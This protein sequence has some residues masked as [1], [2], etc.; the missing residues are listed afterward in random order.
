M[1]NQITDTDNLIDTFK[2]GDALITFIIPTMNRITLF[3]TVHSLLNQT[4]DNWKAILIF[5]GCSPTDKHPLLAL[6]DKRFL[7]ITITKLGKENHAGYIRNIGLE[8]ADTPWVGFVDDDDA[9]TSRYIERLEEEIAI[10]PSADAI[11]FKMADRG[12]IIPPLNYNQI[13]IGEVGISFAYRHSLVKEGFLFEPSSIED[14]TLLKKMQ[15]AKKR[16]VF[17]PH[18]TYLVRFCNYME[19][20]SIRVVFN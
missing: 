17:S 2:G 13:V 11:V 1:S 20:P 14:Y 15:E 5:D 4:K 19:G 9:L 8:L 10:T 6:N 18:V 7:C 16:I 3:N 12:R